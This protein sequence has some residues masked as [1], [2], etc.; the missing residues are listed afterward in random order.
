MK[1]AIDAK[2]INRNCSKL[3]TKMPNVDELIDG[4]SRI[5]IEEKAS[6][7]NFTVLAYKM[8][9]ANRN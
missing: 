5:V 1:P 9:T 6:R 8:R 4:V 2:P 7:L 3:N